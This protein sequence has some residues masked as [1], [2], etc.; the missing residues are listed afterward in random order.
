MHVHDQRT[1]LLKANKIA[2]ASKLMLSASVDSV[3]I[4]SL[5]LRH[6]R[7]AILAQKEK[8]SRICLGIPTP[9]MSF[10]WYCST[11]RAGVPQI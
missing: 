5:G 8:Q 1:L 2:D 6:S 7:L 11:V 4:G 10:P 9:D 3:A